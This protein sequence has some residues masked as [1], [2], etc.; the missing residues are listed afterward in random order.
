MTLPLSLPGVTAGF[1]FVFIP[2][3]GEWVTPSLVGGVQ[4]VMYGN[5]IQDQFVR[6]LNWPLGSLMSLVMLVLM[7]IQ[8]ALFSRV[9]R[10]SDLAGL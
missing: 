8:L 2:T 5:L 4:G 10:L 1:F 9:I 7:L 6:A 3:L